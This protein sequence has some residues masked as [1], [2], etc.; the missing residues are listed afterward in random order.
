MVQQKHGFLEAGER[1]SM[2][3][4]GNQVTLRVHAA[5]ATAIYELDLLSGSLSSKPTVLY[6]YGNVLFFLNYKIGHMQQLSHS[7]SVFCDQE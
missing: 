4:K 1:L 6:A 2:Y 5:D 3:T 7:T